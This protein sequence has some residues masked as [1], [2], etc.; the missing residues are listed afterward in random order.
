MQNMKR[1]AYEEPT[2]EIVRMKGEAQILAGSGVSATIDSP[3]E[4]EW[5]PINPGSRE[6]GLPGSPESFLGLDL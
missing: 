4:E 1:K 2:V 3:T 6:F 5:G